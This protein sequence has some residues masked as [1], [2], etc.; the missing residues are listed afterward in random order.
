MDKFAWF[1]LRER[2]SSLVGSKV[3]EPVT[4]MEPTPFVP[5]TAEGRHEEL[6]WN[7]PY[8]RRFVPATEQ[9]PVAT[10]GWDES[11]GGA[12]K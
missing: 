4:P 5:S 11:M 9:T 1:E 6:M 7:P 12:G 10:H 2:V 3:A 8:A